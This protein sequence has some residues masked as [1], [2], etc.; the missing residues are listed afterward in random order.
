MKLNCKAYEQ[1]SQLQLDRN[2]CAA[3]LNS[4]V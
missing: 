4:K 3:T 1:G 2:S